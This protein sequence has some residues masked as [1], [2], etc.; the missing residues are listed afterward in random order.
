MSLAVQDLVALLDGRLADGLREMTL[1]GAWWTPFE[2][3]GVRRAICNLAR[4]IVS[5]RIAY[6]TLTLD[7]IEIIHRESAILAS[8]SGAS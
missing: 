6:C 7:P 5:G 2:D 1:T 8:R 3:L 4:L